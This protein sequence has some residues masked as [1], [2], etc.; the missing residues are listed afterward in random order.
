MTDYL[1]SPIKR[2]VAGEIIGWHYDPPYNVYDLATDDL[3]ALLNPVYRYHQV[4]D[5]AGNLVGYCCY[6][7]DA[8]VPGGDYARVEPEILDVGVGLHPGLVGQ[9]LGGGFVKAILAYALVNYQ[10]EYFRVSIADFNQ[11]SLNTFRSAGFAVTIHFNRELDGLP[12]TQLE[13]RADGESI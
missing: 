6:G 4:V 3:E 8:R 5:R 9:G 2:E 11:R 12:F 7:E 10:P 13:R 1:L